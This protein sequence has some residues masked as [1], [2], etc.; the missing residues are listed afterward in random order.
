MLASSSPSDHSSSYETD[1]ADI[2]VGATDWP[3]KADLVLVPYPNGGA[4]FSTGSIAWCGALA[5][6]GYDNDI[7][8]I[9]DNVLR[10]FVSGRPLSRSDHDTLH[11]GGRPE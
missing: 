5:H 7:S 11:G 1:P 6:D 3:V 2:P 8:R 4:V 9:T 10:A